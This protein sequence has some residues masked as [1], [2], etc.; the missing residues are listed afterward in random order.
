VDYV[1][2]DLR[3]GNLSF[4]RRMPDSTFWVH[5]GNSMRH[6]RSK[7]M[8]KSGKH[9]LSRFSHPP[10][11]PAISPCNLWLF[12]LLKG[13]LKDLVFSSSDEIEQAI[14]RIRDDLTFGNVQG[15]FQNRMS[16]MASVIEHGE[17]HAQEQKGN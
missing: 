1:F 12:G 13:I 4:H 7:V 6:N 5:I 11:S 16:L 8:S 9:R 15:V 3:K 14:P 17:E 10:F 2:P